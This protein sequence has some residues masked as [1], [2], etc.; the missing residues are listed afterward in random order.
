MPRDRTG[1]FFTFRTFPVFHNIKFWIDD[2]QGFDTA[3]QVSDVIHARPARKDK[4]GRLVASQFDTALINDGT[5]ES[6]GVKGALCVF[7]LPL[8]CSVD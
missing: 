4:H 6:F 7:K 5:G 3:G 8:T 2:V 1:I